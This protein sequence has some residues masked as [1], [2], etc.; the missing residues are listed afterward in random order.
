MAWKL[1]M[2]KNFPSSLRRRKVRSLVLLSY[3]I[4]E[5]PFFIYSFFKMLASCSNQTK[6]KVSVPHGMQ[7][8]NYEEFSN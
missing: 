5:F 3:E 4:S 1:W 2:K 8:M 7:I 6:L